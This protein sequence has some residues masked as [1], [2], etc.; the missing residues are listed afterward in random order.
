M[1]VTVPWGMWYENTQMPLDFPDSWEV[2]VAEMKDAPPLNHDAIITSFANP[3]GSPAIGDLARSKKSAT[4]A[5]DDLTRPTEAFRF[6][7]VLL[8]SIEE[9]GIQ[10]HNINILLALGCHRAMSRDDFVKKLGRDVVDNYRVLNHSPFDNLVDM[11]KSETG[12]PIKVNRF[13]AEAELKIAVG[14]IVPHPNAGWG[15]G[16][17]IVVPGVCAI[18]TLEAFHGPRIGNMNCRVTLLEGNDLRDDIEDIAELV[19]LDLIVNAVNTSLGQT[20]GLF[21]GHPRLAHRAGVDLARQVYRTSV[22]SS[23]DVGV[24]NAFPKDTEFIQ[25]SNALNIWANSEDDLVK[26]G[27]TIV[28]TTAASEGHGCHYLSDFGMRLSKKA[29]ES[30]HMKQKLSGRDLIFYSPKVNQFSIRN[31]YPENTHLFNNW[32]NAV[33]FLKKKHGNSAKALV[34][35]CS[36]MQYL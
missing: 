19:G 23:C 17:K 8:R 3:I 18:D 4:I 22:P 6:L 20:A 11:G 32:Q 35:P 5:V 21:V 36:T 28:I 30:P 31:K 1:K 29:E 33:D 2:T 27:G 9:A 10:K 26:Q 25:S 13:F 16:G 7:P 14:C 12:T 24:F 15:G 34:F